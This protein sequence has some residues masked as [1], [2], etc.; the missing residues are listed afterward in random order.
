M[1]GMMVDAMKVN[2][3]MIKSMAMAYMFGLIKEDIK[4]NGIEVNSMG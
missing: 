3:K 4:V 1:C 2:I